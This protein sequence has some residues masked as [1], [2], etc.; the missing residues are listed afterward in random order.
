MTEA[1]Q[2]KDHTMTDQFTRRDFVSTAAA[3][4]AAAAVSPMAFAARRQDS[5]VVRIGMIGCGGRGTGAAVNAMQAHPAVHI[6]AMA[7]L[8]A[9]RLSGSYGHLQSQEPFKDRVQVQE[10]HRFTGF[11]AYKQLLALEDIDYV[12]L[13]TPPHF[14]PIHFEAAVAAGKHVF[15][16]KPVAVDPAGIRRVIAAGKVADEKNLRVVA[17]TQRRHHIIYLEAMRRIHDGAIGKPV[18]ANCYWNQGGLWV[19]E[20]KP[21]YSDMEWQT[22]NWLY[23]TWLSGDHITEQHVHNLDVC[24]WAF[25]GP[26]VKALGMGGRQVRTAPRYGNIFDHF[27]V[28][29]EYADGSKMTSMCRQIDGCASRVAEVIRGENGAAYLDHGAAR[30]VGGSDWKFTGKAPNPYVVEHADLIAAIMSGHKLN[31]AR[32]V[33]EST[34]TAILGR[35]SAYSGQELTYDEALSADYDLAP[36]AYAFGPLPVR[37]VAVPGKT[38]YT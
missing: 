16:E 10:G 17:G 32:R 7:D 24:N 22:R 34:M 2:G 28:E 5:E 3:V 6:V 38:R 27:A 19:H 20:R 26:P 31:E 15:M 30:F 37:P 25:G 18:S 33:A 23:F 36:P 4:T 12:I 35:M 29:Y 13:A 8:Y 1:E 9:D 11:D 14:R 21:E